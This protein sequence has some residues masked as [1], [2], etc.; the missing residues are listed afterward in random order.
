MSLDFIVNGVGHGNLAAQLIAN[1]LDPG[2]MRPFIGKDGRSYCTVFN[3]LDG[4]GNPTY[5]N[6][7]MNSAA[8][9]R[10]DE[11]IH[12]DTAV[13]K[14]AMPRLKAWA[15]LE[16]AN[17]YTIPNGW[18]KTVLE[19]QN[20]SDISD[21]SVSMDGVVESDNDRPVYDITG[22]PLPI[23]H[24]DFRMSARQ[25]ATSRNSNT[26]LDT[27]NAS[28]AGTKISEMVEKITIGSLVGATFG[29]YTV[30]GYTNWPGRLTADVTAPTTGGW[31]PEILINE[32]LI[33]RDQSINAHY[34]GPW[35][36]YFGLGWTAYLD[37]DYSALKGDLT[38]RDRILKLDG[39]T[40]VSTL[41]FLTGFQ[42][43][44]VQMTPEVARAV[45]AMRPQTLQWEEKG[46]MEICMK[47]MC[48]MVPQLRTDHYGN[49][50]IVHA[51]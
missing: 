30:H 42:I 48:V 33:M 1:N 20:V 13:I 19:S 38:V 8:L 32:I 35:K 15:D 29:G 12:F 44:M 28:L 23:I 36:L 26:P 51:T 49:T 9:L 46:G 18:G 3:G 4:Q 24:K 11:W 6:V 10:K 50:G 22:L 40:G 31:T 41:D 27:T 2:F 37:M 43:L 14:A 21:A 47:V 7:V 45:I 16:M 34:Y 25:I 17:S 5:R 39:V